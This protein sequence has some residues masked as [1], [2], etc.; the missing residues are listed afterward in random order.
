MGATPAL[1]GSHVPGQDGLPQPLGG[2]PPSRL[3]GRHRLRAYPPSHG[4]ILNN[5]HKIVNN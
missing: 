3:A 5:V 1:P 2:G 4:A